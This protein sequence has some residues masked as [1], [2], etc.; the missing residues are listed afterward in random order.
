[1]LPDLAAWQWAL[2]AF[3]A[4][5][6]GMAKTGVPGVA[7][8][9][10]PLMVLTVGDARHSAA[11]TAPI[12]ITADVFAVTYWRRHTEA[13]ALFKLIPWVAGGMVAGGFALSLS[14][15]VL[16][17]AVGV[18]VLTMLVLNVAQRKGMTLS[19]ARS[20][21]FYGVVAG[22][23]TTVANAAGPVM[24][25]YLLMQRLPKEQFVATGAWFFF[26]VNLVKLPIYATH[27]LFSRSSLMF[28]LM[29]V[30]PVVSGALSGLWLVHRIPQRS[31]ETL[32]VAFTIVSSILL[33]R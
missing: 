24:N 17:R 32:V 14:E 20:A 15:P 12:L 25:L 8:M 23:A 33:F 27:D 11:W 2:G 26:V 10:V 22:F 21:G 31:F 13:R 9:T 6:I 3:C 5:L 1:V 4:L 29:M 18:I 30:P 28:D 16:R 19:A 7:T